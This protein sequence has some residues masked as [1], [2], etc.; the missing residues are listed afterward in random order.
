MPL[1]LDFVTITI[2]SRNENKDF[3]LLRYFLMYFQQVIK[4]NKNSFSHH[5]PQRGNVGSGADFNPCSGDPWLKPILR[6][7]HIATLQITI[8]NNKKFLKT[9][10]SS[11][12][13][14]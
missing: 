7:M 5:S 11:L 8:K 10:T 13:V 6:L 2:P 12:D 4:T 3:K 1:F 14:L 9:N